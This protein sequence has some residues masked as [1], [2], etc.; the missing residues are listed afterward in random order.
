[1]QGYFSTYLKSFQI[2]M[3]IITIFKIIL[4]PFCGL[5][6]FYVTDKPQFTFKKN[7]N[8]KDALCILLQ[9]HL[10]YNI[11]RNGRKSYTQADASDC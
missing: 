8:Q 1:M 11:F 4:L 5:D 9:I 2:M 6:F 10:P 3:Y 7:I